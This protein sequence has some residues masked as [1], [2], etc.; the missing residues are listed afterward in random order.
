MEQLA[1]GKRVQALIVLVECGNLGRSNWYSK[2][3]WLKA[4]WIIIDA[5]ID[6]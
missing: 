2:S 4:H 1:G 5:T 3:S 6:L